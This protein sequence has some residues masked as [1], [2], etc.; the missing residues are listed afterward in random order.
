[1]KK[2]KIKRFKNFYNI[3]K[4]INVIEVFLI[5]FFSFILFRIF[6]LNIINGDYYKILLKNK[7]DNIVYGDSA[8][9]GRIYDR[10]MKLLVDNVAVKSIYYK[11]EKNISRTDEIALAYSLIDI[12]S[13]DYDNLSTRNL[14]EFYYILYE[15]DV[16]NKITESE[17]D[18][19]ENRKITSEEIESLKFERITSEDLSV[20]NEDDKKAAYLY[21]LMNKGYYYDEKEIKIDNVT[22]YE[23]A[24]ISENKDILRGFYTKLEWD[25][26]YLYGDTLRGILGSVSSKNEGIPYEEKDYYLSLGYNLNDRVGLSGLEKEYESVL[27]GNKAEYKINDDNSLSLISEGKRGNDIV[28][29][30]D[31]DLQLAIDN[32]LEDEVIKTKSEANTEF[33]NHSFIVIQNPQ[34]GE[35]M[36]MSGK[37]LYE[38]NK[39]RYKV[40]DFSEGNIISTVTPGSVVKGASIIV[41]YNEGVIKIGTV[42]QDRCIKLYNLPEKCS[43]KMLGTINDLDALKYSSNVYQYKIAMMVGGFDYKYNKELKIDVEAFDK[44]RSLFYQFGLGSSTGIDYPKEEDGYKGN[45]YAG[46]LLINYSIGQYDTYTPLQLSQYVS[47]IANG[48]SRYKPHFL[49]QVLSS[50]GEVLYDVIPTILNKVDTDK[51]YMKRVQEGFKLVMSSGT[52]RFGYMG[53]SYHPAGKT[54]TSESFVDI[55]GDGV[56][57]FESISNNFVG[58]APYDNPIMSIVASSPDVQNPNRGSYKSDVNLRISRAASNIFFKFYDK[59]GNRK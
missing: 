22:D 33:Y 50:E 17:Y 51:K 9:R 35:I 57:D 44:Y 6:Y 41:G 46:D 21:Y 48:G 14:K 19:L 4:R 31:I 25:R 11:K 15:D 40:Y 54:G 58:Y 56:V 47:T 43:W 28:L 49:K 26:V 16:N 36:S 1:M 32:M 52:G 45:S 34:N 37:Q 29:S 55:N 13:L 39:G 38:T 23:Y 18:D 2:K 12:L 42:M 8:P 59:K 30:I 27:K 53:N 20:F 5:A 7:T 10:N 24:Y 3:N